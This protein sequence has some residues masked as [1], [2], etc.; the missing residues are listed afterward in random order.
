MRC[1][2]DTSSTSATPG[3][4][5]KYRHASA[6]GTIADVARKVIDFLLVGHSQ[7]SLRLATLVSEG[8]FNGRPRN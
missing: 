7:P 5:S 2:S 8:V 1:Q 3:P 4:A 6:H